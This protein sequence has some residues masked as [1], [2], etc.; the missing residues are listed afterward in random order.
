MYNR[1]TRGL[2]I[3]KQ[4]VVAAVPAQRRHAQKT[5][6]LAA[7]FRRAFDRSARPAA[8]RTAQAGYRAQTRARMR[9]RA[10][11][12]EAGAAALTAKQRHSFDLDAKREQAKH[13]AQKASPRRHITS[14][15]V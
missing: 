6:T 12:V 11:A 13:A 10:Q 8:A 9:P 3:V 2:C 14:K 4:A 7:E 1:S 15:T 5:C